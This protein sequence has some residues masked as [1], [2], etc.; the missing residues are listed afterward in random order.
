MR[1][2]GR[3]VRRTALVSGTT[4]ISRALGFVR[5]S[6]AAALFGDRSGIYDAFLTAWR[7][8]G[9]FRRF[10]GEGA[11]AASFQAALTRADVDQGEEAGRRLFWATA[12]ALT[13]SLVAATAVFMGA[14]ALAPD[15]MPWTGWRW[16]GADPGPVR[17]LA[18][19]VM[20]Y[21]VLVCLAALVSGA[22]QVRGVFGPPAWSSAA[23]N[24]VWLATLAV[25]VVRF[26]TVGP[27]PAEDGG[28]R[29]LAMTRWLAV[30][31][32][33]SGVAQLSVQLPALRGAGLGRRPPGAR[34]P[35]VPDA[36]ARDALRSAVPLA[37]GAAVF[38]V[39]EVVD[40]FMAE[41]LL[42]DGAPTVLYLANRVQQL[43][44]ALVAFAAAS[45]VFP[46][47][48][49]HG[50]LGDRR[51]VRRLVDR[52]Q[53]GVALLGVPASVGL[54]VLASPVAEVV[55]GHGAFGPEGVART[56][57]TLQALALAIL[58][59]GATSLVV[60]AYYAL[61]DYRWPVRVALAM[62]AVNAGL[63]TLCLRGFGLDVEGLALATVATSWLNLAL[64][65]PG[66][67]RLGLPRSEE[68]LLGPLAAIAAASAGCGVVA[69]VTWRA[70]AADLG[71]A[72]AL[73]A[74]IAGAILAYGAAVWA[75]AVP[76]VR[77]LGARLRSR[78]SR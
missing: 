71:E 52:T 53:L 32:L 1:R 6:L 15:T 66:L 20:P 74:A 44:L 49:A 65:G 29:H 45:A 48:Q 39:N 36:G 2:H 68:P 3:L 51:A 75:L 43:P 30:G 77:E 40:G 59:V 67:T 28:A 46:A 70:L 34:A 41:A 61:G 4:G 31:A 62:L 18:L 55:Y 76:G 69:H 37:F 42:P 9:L 33:L 14:L 78:F 50:H 24:V 27:G 60:R 26:G 5:E 11:I 25:I 64:L 57:R 23:L 16:L 8:P 35:V 63:N 7:V 56:A 19:R 38:Q 10:V 47:L 73:G 21:V 12:R 54:C 72:P 58:P 22:L 17:E 13:A